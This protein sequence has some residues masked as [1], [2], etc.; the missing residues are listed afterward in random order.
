MTSDVQVNMS[1]NAD[2]LTQ[3]RTAMLGHWN[4]WNRES[5][6]SVGL[7]RFFLAM[8]ITYLLMAALFE[9]YLYPLVILF[10]VPP[11]TVG[12]FIGLR[13]VGTSTR[14]SNWTR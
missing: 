4:G 11:A 5:L 13:L 3:V 14:R 6:L 7:S 9:S 2:K 1:G 8:L 10:S 12:G